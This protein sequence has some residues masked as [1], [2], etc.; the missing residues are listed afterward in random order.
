MKGVSSRWKVI[1]RGYEKGTVQQFKRQSNKGQHVAFDERGR[2][3]LAAVN[4]M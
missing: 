3:T 1:S 2:W 4:V